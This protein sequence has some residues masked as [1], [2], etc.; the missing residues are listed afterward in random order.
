MRD[1]EI[2]QYPSEFQKWYH[3]FIKG[4]Q[5]GDASSEELKELYQEWKNIGRPNVK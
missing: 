3:R 4:N 5:R 2:Q 1:A